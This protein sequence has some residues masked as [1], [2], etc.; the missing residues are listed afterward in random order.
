MLTNYPTILKNTIQYVKEN[1]INEN[2][3]KLYN[4]ELNH[5]FGYAE[6]KEEQEINQDSSLSEQ[7]RKQ[8]LAKIDDILEV[9]YFL[10]YDRIP[11]ETI[12]DVIFEIRQVHKN[13]NGSEYEEPFLGEKV[14]KYIDRIVKEKTESKV[15]ELNLNA[16]TQFEEDA[17][18][19][20]TKVLEEGISEEDFN[21]I[22]KSSFEE[23]SKNTRY[24]YRMNKER[25]IN[26]I[27]SNAKDKFQDG[28]QS[29]KAKSKVKEALTTYGNSKKQELEKYGI[30]TE[31][32]NK[33]I[34][35]IVDNLRFDIRHDGK[36][37]KVVEN[38]TNESKK[39]F[40]NQIEPFKNKYVFKE[41]FKE[42]V[43]AQKKEL[44]KFDVTDE[45]LK[46]ELNTIINNLEWGIQIGIAILKSY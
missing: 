19:Q 3:A 35:G 6:M 42:Y 43:D 25:E 23:V 46:N 30:S 29:L 40:E 15:K 38:L 13:A 44:L 14:E 22:L 9:K 18:S 17:N 7:Q 27:I 21:I 8:L 16:K 33:V 5:I 4:Y 11:F 20:K 2:T 26:S 41:K 31:K 10:G 45:I 12:N 34:T 24:F 37:E 32:I 36:F 39:Y 1:Q 28:I